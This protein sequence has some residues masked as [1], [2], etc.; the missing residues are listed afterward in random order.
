M[1]KKDSVMTNEVVGHV[2]NAMTTIIEVKVI[3]H[4]ATNNTLDKDKIMKQ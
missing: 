3:G 1:Q 2:T 4:K